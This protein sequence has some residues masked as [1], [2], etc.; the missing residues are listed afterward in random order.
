MESQITIDENEYGYGNNHLRKSM[1]LCLLNR[2][3]WW[4]NPIIDR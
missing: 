3:K 4:Y 1:V 2:G